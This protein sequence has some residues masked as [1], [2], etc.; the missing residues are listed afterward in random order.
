MNISNHYIYHEFI[1]CYVIL[2]L[3]ICILVSPDL[4]YVGPGRS[5]RSCSPI[6]SAWP[7]STS[8][9][10]L[11]KWL[12][13][14]P[15]RSSVKTSV[16]NQRMWVTH[17]HSAYSWPG[18]GFIKQLVFLLY[19]WREYTVFCSHPLNF[20]FLT[21]AFPLFLADYHVSYSLASRS[22]KYGILHK[23][24]VAQGNDVITVRKL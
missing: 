6:R 15:W 3:V 4:R 13:R 17:F 2:N 12:V 23:R 16:W 5:L 9:R 19:F 24:W 10:A 20:F 11:T 1:H 8:M 7:G 18:P 21:Y 14:R 22:S